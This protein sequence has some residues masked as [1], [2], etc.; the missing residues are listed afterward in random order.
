VRSAVLLLALLCAG[1]PLRG[2]DDDATEPFDPSVLPMGPNPPRQPTMATVQQIFDGDTGRFR[3]DSGETRSVRFLSIDT[4]EENAGS[5]DPAECW[6]NEATARTEEMLPE[7][8]RVWLTWDG[9]EQDGFDRLLC[10]IFRGEHPEGG[11]ASPDWVN[12]TLV[13]EGHARA[14]IFSNNQTYR[15]VFESAEAA[16]RNEDLGRWGACG[17]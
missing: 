9:E 17:F 5:G 14:F 6:A 16:A 8:T 10:Y 13:R 2:D 3:L 1:C 11:D 12:Y 7:G 15:D 4:P